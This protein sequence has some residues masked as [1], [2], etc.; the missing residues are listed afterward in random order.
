M[1]RSGP[2]RVL[3]V[4]I[5]VYNESATFVTL[6]E[7][8][9]AKTIEGVAIEII[10][11]ESNSTDGSR[12]LVL[13]YRD[14]PRVRVI[15]EE[16]PQGKG[17]AIRAGLREAS[18]E[19]ILF[20]DADLEYDVDDYDALVEPILRGEAD[21]VLGSRHS[22]GKYSSKI[23][24]FADSPI[25]AAFFNFG[26]WLFLT[27]FNLLYNV[28]LSDPFTMYKVFHRK[29]LEGLSF[30][31]NR[32]D[33]DHEI[34]IK[35]LLKGYRPLELPVN[36]RSRSLREGKKVTLFRDPLTWLYALVRFRIRSWF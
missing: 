21:F 20:Q 29:C 30:E 32:F 33:F 8:V 2:A 26:H 7:R 12:D 16:R 28:H 15:L 31:C 25:T 13:R 9:L 22:G 35:F 4:I 17:H 24:Q 34:V 18:G 19:V 11:V 6:M 3:S 27:L 23:R 10:V 5:P 36:Y 14:R 1:T